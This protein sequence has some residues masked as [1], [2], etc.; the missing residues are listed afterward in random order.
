[1]IT[2]ANEGKYGGGRR[3]GFRLLADRRN[4]QR[5]L[6]QNLENGR[7]GQSVNEVGIS[8]IPI[9]TLEL[10]AEDDSANR[11]T[12]WQRYFERVTLGR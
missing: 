7:N 5:S 10:I 1:M 2:Q 6:L 8:C 12:D 4:E 3:R 11:K 9:E